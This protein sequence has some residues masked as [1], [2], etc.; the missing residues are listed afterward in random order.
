MQLTR[1]SKIYIQ[2]KC[3]W[4]A[5]AILMTLATEFFAPAKGYVTEPLPPD[6]VAQPIEPI[7]W[8]PRALTQEQHCSAEG[9]QGTDYC[10]D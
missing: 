10:D 2:A 3:S 8:C 9:R 5:L 1:C 7:I 6:T 4:I